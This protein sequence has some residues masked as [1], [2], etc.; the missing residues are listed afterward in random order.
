MNREDTKAHLIKW[1]LKFLNDGL[2]KVTQNEDP[3]KNR[4]NKC[5]VDARFNEWLECHPGYVGMKDD[6]YILEFKHGKK[7]TFRIERDFKSDV[8]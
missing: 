4:A 7:A 6:G 3:I 8:V 5:E 1:L 2:F